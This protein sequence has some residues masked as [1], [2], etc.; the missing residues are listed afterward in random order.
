[1][2]EDEEKGACPNCGC[3]ALD[4]RGLWVCQCPAPQTAFERAAMWMDARPA[5]EKH[6]ELVA[7]SGFAGQT[8][9]AATAL[10]ESSRP[11]L[12]PGSPKP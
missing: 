10:A 1:M 7:R 3:E 6:N 2:I 12:A 8:V 9:T 11:A 4:H 5:I